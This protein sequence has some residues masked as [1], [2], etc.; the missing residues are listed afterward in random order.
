MSSISSA[1]GSLMYIMCTY[2]DTSFAIGLISHSKV[3]LHMVIES[4]QEDSSLFTWNDQLHTLLSIR[5]TRL[6]DCTDIDYGDDLEERKYI[7]EY[8]FS[9]NATVICW[10]S[11]KQYCIILSTIESKYIACAPT[12]SETAWL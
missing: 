12:I 4:V 9:L 11:K 10:S 1:V 7:V 8:A 2:P 3:I 6:C 5:D